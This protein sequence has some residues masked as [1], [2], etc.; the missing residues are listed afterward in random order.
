MEPSQHYKDF[1]SFNRT[2]RS[3]MQNISA[4][5]K[6]TREQNNVLLSKARSIATREGY[7]TGLTRHVHKALQE[8][9]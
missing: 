2:A 9:D 8:I 6:W 7:A 1:Y 4:E 5:R 3:Q